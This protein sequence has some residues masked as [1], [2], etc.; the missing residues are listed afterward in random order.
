M[1]ETE[2]TTSKD[3]PECIFHHYLDSCSIGEK[4]FAQKPLTEKQINTIKDSSAQRKDSLG[5]N[6]KDF[7]KWSYHTSCY[8][9]YTSKS[10]IEKFQKQKSKRK[11]ENQ[12]EQEGPKRKVLRSANL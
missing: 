2:E 11:Q 10:K 12:Q 7:T 3:S 8:A 9:T 1:E 4:V 5:K 6:I